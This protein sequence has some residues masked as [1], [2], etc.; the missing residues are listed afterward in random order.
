VAK[1]LIYLH[2]KFHIFLRSLIISS[3]YYPTCLENQ[4]G[5][6]EFK[7]G[8]S[9]WAVFSAPAQ[10]NSVPAQ[11]RARDRPITA[12][13]PQSP[14]PGAHMS[15]SNSPIPSPALADPHHRRDSGQT[16]TRASG[17]GCLMPPHPILLLLA[18]NCGLYHHLTSVVPSSFRCSTV[19]SLH[20]RDVGAR[21]S[22][23]RPPIAHPTNRAGAVEGVP[24]RPRHSPT[25]VR[26]WPP[27]CGAP[28]H[29]AWTPLHPTL[30][31][32]ARTTAYGQISFG[33]VCMQIPCRCPPH[34]A[35]VPMRARSRCPS[36]AER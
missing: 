16:V 18:N 22:I 10:H 34:C 29:T 20:G 7:I 25:D 19:S 8:K 26:A 36:M 30:S 15:G 35:P 11:T 33:V 3:N 6:S 32:V 1:I 14:P 12:C 9:S 2:A 28:S 27:R 13:A 5:K 24:S 4:K 21:S 31:S 23:T 17:Q